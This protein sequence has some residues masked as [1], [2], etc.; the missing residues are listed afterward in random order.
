VLISYLRADSTMIIG[1]LGT[2]DFKKGYYCYVGSANGK[3]ISVESRTARHKRLASE[4]KGNIKW[5]IDY[6]LTSPNVSVKAVKKVED[7][8]ECKVSKILEGIADKTIKGFGSS[9]CKEGCI[10]HMHYFESVPRMDGV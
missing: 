4:K 6:F 10:G 3:S 7:G 2:I 9:D 8:K 5:H 1:K